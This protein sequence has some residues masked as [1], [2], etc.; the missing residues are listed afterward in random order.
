M[1]NNYSI[2]E[3]AESELY[4]IKVLQGH[5]SDIVYTYGKVQIIENKKEDTAKLKFDFKIEEVPDNHDMDDLM[6][7]TQFKNEIG[8]ILSDILSE[9]KIGNA[10]ST[11]NNIEVANEE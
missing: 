7:D 4:S 5:Y 1:S 11:D 9:G 8:D 6:E 3:R 2:V 10:G